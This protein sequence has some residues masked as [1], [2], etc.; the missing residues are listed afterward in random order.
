MVSG[1]PL[2][3]AV[4]SGQQFPLLFL[5]ASVLSVNSLSS[6]GP[7]AVMGSKNAA[8]GEAT[9]PGSLAHRKVTGLSTAR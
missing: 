6:P 5:A 1:S 2:K 8:W 7:R 9:H 3:S 4:L